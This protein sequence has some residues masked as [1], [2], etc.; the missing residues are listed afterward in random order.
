MILAKEVYV[1]PLCR[2]VRARLQ[3]AAAPVFSGP[4]EELA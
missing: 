3:N 1:Y 2:N 4:D